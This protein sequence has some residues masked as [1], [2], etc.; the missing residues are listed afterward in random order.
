[1]ID[2]E[3]NVL[4]RELKIHEKLKIDLIIQMQRDKVEAI[5]EQKARE[6]E[7]LMA[8]RQ[9]QIDMWVFYFDFGICRY[10]HII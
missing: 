3:D 8:R 1:M 6:K 10:I 4:F 2:E 5:E 9:L 7:D